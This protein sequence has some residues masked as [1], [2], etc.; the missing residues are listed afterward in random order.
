TTNFSLYQDIN[1]NTLCVNTSLW[2]SE[3][4]F[5][6]CAGGTG[7]EGYFSYTNGMFSYSN[8][9]K[10]TITL[11]NLC[12]T[13][14][15][16][17]YF[18]VSSQGN[19]PVNPNVTERK[20]REVVEFENNTLNI[21]PN[22]VTNRLTIE[23]NSATDDVVEISLTDVLGKQ[24]SVLMPITAIKKGNFKQTF[25]VSMLPAGMYSYQIKTSNTIQTG[26]ISK[27]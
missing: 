5:V 9:Y 25:D 3:T 19:M 14:S 8:Y 10:I 1:L 2:G 27:N 12:G 23:F 17:S 4:G 20:Q 13:S 16:Y 26:I 22:P 15:D 18:Y 7:Y 24:T 6:S 21:Y 11:S